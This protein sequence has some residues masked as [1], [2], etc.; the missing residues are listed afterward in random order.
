MAR[1]HARGWT[2]RMVAALT[3]VGLQGNA[4]TLWAQADGHPF[5]DQPAAVTPV[6]RQADDPARPKPADDRRAEQRIRE[7]LRMSTRMEFIETP[8]QDAVDYLKDFHAI[9]I[10]LDQ[11]ALED[12]GLG[13]DTPVTGTLK[14][15]SLDSALKLLLSKYGLTSIV[16]N[17]VLLIT[18]PN[19]VAGMIELRVYDVGDLVQDGNVYDLSEILRL[20]LVPA[21]SKTIGGVVPSVSTSAARPH[22]QAPS[23]RPAEEI[24]PA[25]PQESW[26]AM[27]SGS[28]STIMPYGKLIVV[29]GSIVEHEAIAALL[30]DMRTA[31]RHAGK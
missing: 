1:F 15:M 9:E 3:L 10:Q 21:K 31:L 25:A 13:S 30:E 22:P 14:G 12:D 27:P 18:T 2:V 24:A 8:L 11:R 6:E 23:H 5:G 17:G 29:R 16:H 28:G 19:A 7:A 26:R 20:A 4:V